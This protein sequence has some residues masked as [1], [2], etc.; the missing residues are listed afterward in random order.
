MEVLINASANKS[1]IKTIQSLGRILRKKE[2]KDNCTYYDFID[3]VH[4]ILFIASRSRT[5]AF[6][7]EGHEIMYE[8][9]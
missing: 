9:L 1:D 8:E 3:D 5:R 7:K 2:G 6:E 4:K